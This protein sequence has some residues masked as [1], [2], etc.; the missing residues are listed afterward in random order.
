[1]LVYLKDGSAQT[2]V[3]A[4]TLRYK[5]QIKL[6]TSHSHSILTPGRPAP[7]LTLCQAPG[8]VATGVAVLKSLVWLDPEKSCRKW[9][10]NPGSSAPEADTL[11]TRP[12]R[13]WISEECPILTVVSERS[14]FPGFPTTMVYLYYI[15][16]L[17]YTI[18]AGNPS[19]LFEV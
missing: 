18:L 4:A 3:C 14:T 9:D 8:R 12:M 5:L 19:F 15:S 17:R 6:S 1:M 13:W 11:T 10:L 7:A 2:I 16:C